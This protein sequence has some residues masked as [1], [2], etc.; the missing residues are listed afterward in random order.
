MKI[1][2]DLRDVSKNPKAVTIGNF[3]GVHKGHQALINKTKEVSTKNNVESLIFTF[4]KLP[5]EIF[6]PDT[7]QRLYDNKFKESILS[8]YKIDTLLSIDF[9]EIKDYSADF[10]CEEILIKKLNA[11][12]LIIGENFKFGKDRS[13]DIER[14][15]KYDNKKAFELMVPEL[16]T[17]DG[18]KISSSRIR[19]LLNQGDIIGARECLGRDYMLSGTVISGEKLGRKLGYPTANIKLEYNYPLD[20]VYLTKTV[21]E[22]KNYVG[23]ASLGNKPTFNGSEKLLEVFILDFDEDI[24]GK[25]VEVYFLEEIRKQ[26]KFSNEDELIKQ[27]NEDHNYAII[28]SKKYGI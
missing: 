12:Y 27:M 8:S 16:K 18:V 21:I 2:N 26:I 1:L 7:V 15:R 17:Y 11:Q 6:S 24:Y 22:E 4:N 20:G 3:D 14:L 13:G 5:K 23:L 19:N 25:Y 9:N 10:F 28:N